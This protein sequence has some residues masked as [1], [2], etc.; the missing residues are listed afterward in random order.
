MYLLLEKIKGILEGQSDAPKVMYGA[1]NPKALDVGKNGS[2]LLIRGNE[3]AN[4]LETHTERIVTFYMELW[5]KEH[6][7]DVGNAYESIDRLE[8]VVDGALTDYREKVLSLYE[9][10]AFLND[11]L[12]VLDVVITDKVGDMDSMRPLIGVQYTVQVRLYERYGYTI[13]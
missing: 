1:I 5:T 13:W 10:D 7:K 11:N 3:T 6:G 9:E 8:Q 2:V 12:Q 4:Q